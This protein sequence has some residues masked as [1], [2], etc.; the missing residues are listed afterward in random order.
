MGLQTTRAFLEELKG[1]LQL[2]MVQKDLL[3]HAG[4]PADIWPG[5]M[6][7]QY[8]TTAYA[9]TLLNHKDTL[10]R[11]LFGFYLGAMKAHKLV[12]VQAGQ[13][14]ARFILEIQQGFPGE[15]LVPP[16]SQVTAGPRSVRWSR[17]RIK[18]ETSANQPKVVAQ[19]VRIETSAEARVAVCQELHVQMSG[20]V[21]TAIVF[22]SATCTMSGEIG[23]LY[24]LKGADYPTINM[25]AEI[26]NI[27]ELD[28][29]ALVAKAAE[30]GVQLETN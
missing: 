8:D 22:G 10:N 11:Y 14:I 17:P 9:M 21:E 28:F 23:T 6:H 18:L 19:S 20:E 30:Y 24:L 29:A 26:G 25:S 16:T 4:V 7:T 3:T 15:R 1:Y 13:Q 2:S 5:N 12:G 27:V